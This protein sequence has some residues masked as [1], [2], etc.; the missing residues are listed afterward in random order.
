MEQSLVQQHLHERLNAA[1]A[2]ELRHHVFAART[3]VREHRHA[4][5]DAREII[6]LERH[7]GRVR[8]RK[9]MQHG[10]RRTAERDHDGDRILERFARENL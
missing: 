2:N 8:H 7:A 5:A 4:L 10:I 6:E 1:D 3:Q 9:K